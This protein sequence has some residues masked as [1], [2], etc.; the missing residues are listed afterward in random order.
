MIQQVFHGTNSGYS[1]DIDQSTAVSME[2]KYDQIWMY[3][4]ILMT[5]GVFSS[6]KSGYSQ[7]L[8]RQSPSIRPEQSACRMRSRCFRRLAA[9][10]VSSPSWKS[11]CDGRMDGDGVNHV[12]M[13]ISW[14][15]SGNIIGMHS[16]FHDN[17]ITGM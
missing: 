5:P 2:Q 3:P 16:Q 13:E 1:P 11:A 14:T 6:K 7:N 9:V 10:K 12:S 8:A 15:Y 17:W 4:D